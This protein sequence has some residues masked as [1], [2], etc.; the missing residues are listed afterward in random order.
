MTTPQTTDE[1]TGPGQTTLAPHL[2]C[3]KAAAAIEFY[4]QA[5][6]AVEMI[7]L[8][9][10]DGRLMHA[11][12]TINGAMVMLVDEF[13]EQGGLGPNA[14]GGTPVK[15]H[16]NV[17]DADAVHDRAVAAGATSIIKVAQ[18]F[19][20][21]RYGLVQDPFGHRWAIATPGKDAPRT[22]AGLQEAL[23]KAANT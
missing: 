10:P 5:F 12:I 15:I 14:L 23:A 13:P 7:R 18:Q 1:S 6:G 4:K 11:S 20:G 8:P 3:A 17:A 21:D 16:L 19:W 9:G 2:T 22:N